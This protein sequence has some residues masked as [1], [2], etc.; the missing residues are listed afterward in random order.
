MS[1]Q[2]LRVLFRK[3]E[4]V[5]Y[6]SHLD[7]LR[8]WER[9]IRRAGLPLAY[10][11]GFTPH[12]KLAFASPLPL[13]FTGEREVMD[14]T[15]DERIDPAEFRR[16]LVEQDTEDLAL[17]E[18]REVPLAAPAPQSAMLWSD[19][20]VVVPGLDPDAARQAVH[21]FLASDSLPWREERGERVREYD[22]RRATAWLTVRP[23]DGGAELS[24]RLQSD[25][26]LTARPEAILSALFPGHEPAG[27]V[28]T[29][30]VLDERSPARELWRRYGQYQ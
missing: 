20:R 6:I 28:R 4:R 30:I 12:P 19:F 5:K 10:S 14:V 3:G 24:M 7:V 9:A 27:Y 29:G 18:V 1:A 22:L 13:G 17:V 23:I 8:Y 11:Q 16:R 2:R 15:L 25:Q 21:E 26:D